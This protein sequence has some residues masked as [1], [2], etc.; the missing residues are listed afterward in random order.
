MMRDENQSKKYEKLLFL[1]QNWR[2]YFNGR[3]AASQ[4]AYEG[5]IPFARSIDKSYL[6]AV[7]YLKPVRRKMLL[8]DGPIQRPYNTSCILQGRRR[9]SSAAAASI[10]PAFRRCWGCADFGAFGRAVLVGAG[11]LPA[12]RPPS[13]P[14]VL[15]QRRC[16]TRLLVSLRPRRA[17]ISGRRAPCCL[18]STHHGHPGLQRSR[19]QQHARK[20]Y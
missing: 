20:F 4:A 13:Y 7:G 9:Q 6:I 15:D 14:V 18:R 2:A 11:L 19:Y 8:I 10:A 16:L 12:P 1:L 3:T 17:Q 5:S